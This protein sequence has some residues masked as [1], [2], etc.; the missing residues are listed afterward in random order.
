[1]K[2]NNNS[3]PEKTKSEL[4]KELTKYKEEGCALYKGKK[5]EEAKGKFKE[6]FDKYENEISSLTKDS[7]NDE[8]Y[9]EIILLG[10]KILSNLAL[11][12]YKQGDYS[13]AITYDFKLLNDHPNFGKSIVRLFKSSCKL[14]KIKEAV[15]YG[16]LL[17]KLDEETRNKFK[18]TE[19]K[20]K[21]VQL[22]LEKIKKEEEEERKKNSSGKYFLPCVILCI[23]VLFY[24]LRKK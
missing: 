7:S 15:Y 20:V 21:E 14:N 6:G 2:E 10:K 8:E 18:G 5:I 24:L 12:Y 3:T 16:E 19:K 22:K 4:I 17:L 1:M 9:N 23:A 11:C 13:N